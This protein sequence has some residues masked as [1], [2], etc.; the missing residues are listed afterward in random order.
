MRKIHAIVQTRFQFFLRS[1]TVSLYLNNMQ[2]TEP[3]ERPESFWANLPRVKH[4]RAVIDQA[5]QWEENN[6]TIIQTHSSFSGMNSF[7]STDEF[8]PD[9]GCQCDL[10]GEASTITC[11]PTQEVAIPLMLKRNI[12]P[13][14]I[15]VSN[16]DEETEDAPTPIRRRQGIVYMCLIADSTEDDTIIESESSSS[17]PSFDPITFP[18]SPKVIDLL[19]YMKPS[20]VLKSELDSDTPAYVPIS[21]SD[22]LN[23]DSVATRGYVHISNEKSDNIDSSMVGVCMDAGA[24]EVTS[25]DSSNIDS[26]ATRGC[27]YISDEKS[28]NIDS[29]SVDEIVD[30]TADSPTFTDSSNI[31]SVAT[32]GCV[33]I[34]DAK[35]GNIESV[36]AVT[37]GHL[38]VPRMPFSVQSSRMAVATQKWVTRLKSARVNDQ[39]TLKSAEAEARAMMRTRPLYTSKQTPVCAPAKFATRIS[40]DPRGQEP[41]IQSVSRSINPRKSRSNTTHIKSVT[42]SPKPATRPINSVTFSPKLAT[43]HVTLSPKPARRPI[44]PPTLPHK[45]VTRPG[46]SVCRLSKILPRRPRTFLRA[47]H[48]LEAELPQTIQPT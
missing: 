4:R 10:I 7:L 27:V 19:F 20:P 47:K 45:P 35:S 22:S 2:Q 28:G 1:P 36:A 33:H 8:F 41:V 18:T 31:D 39:A 5:S 6:P 24:T 42:L 32:R 13:L 12:P 17:L 46:K 14:T 48:E 26:A 29:N 44:K 11:V 37:V 34:S 38:R 30:T 40:E 25:S 21:T 9:D 3:N 23:I 15:D 16:L 43:R